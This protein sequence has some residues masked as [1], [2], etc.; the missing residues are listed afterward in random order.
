LLPLLLSLLLLVFCVTLCSLCVLRHSL[1]GH[2]SRTPS[3]LLLAL[4]LLL[5]LRPWL[6]L[7]L[8]KVITGCLQLLL[9]AL[10]Q[11]LQL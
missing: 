4:P 5:L 1:Q 7:L 10:P 11:S 9:L 6:L 2:G 8:L 3:L